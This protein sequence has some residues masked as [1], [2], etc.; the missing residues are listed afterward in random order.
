MLSRLL[1]RARTATRAG[2]ATTGAAAAQPL[3]LALNEAFARVQ[4]GDADGAQRAAEQAL[5]LRPDHAD[6]LYLRGLAEALRGA[7]ETA[8]EWFGR[9]RRA[10]PANAAF[11]FSAGLSARTLGR[12]EEAIAAWREAAR[13]DPQDPGTLD[14]L[15]VALLDAGRADEALAALSAAAALAGQD[16]QVAFHLGNALRAAGDEEAAAA[17]FEHACALRPEDARLHN[18]L[19]VALHA[20][21]R[22]SEA[23]SAFDRALA[24][25]GRYADAHN[26]RGSALQGLERTE[27]AVAAFARAL[28][29]DPGHPFALAN[30]AQALQETGRWR[31]AM[32]GFAAAAAAGSAGARLRHALVLPVIPASTGEI[33]EARGRIGPALDAIEAGGVTIADPLAEV[34][35]ANFHLAYHGECNRDL[36]ARIARAH[37]AACPSLAWTAPHVDR[38]RRPGRLRIGFLSRFLRAHSIGK[39]SRGLITRFS[40]ED[41]EVSCIHVPPVSGDE[42]ALAI[43]A[44][45]DRNAVLPLRLQAAREAVAALELDALFY[46]DIGMDPF[47]YLLAFARLAPVQ[48]LSFGH[49]DT[50]GIPNMDWFVSSDL[51]EPP[52]GASHYSER[53]WQA[54]DAGTLAWYLRPPAPDPAITRETLGLPADRPLYFCPHTHFRLHPEFDALLRAILEADPRGELLLIESRQPHWTRL[55]LERLGRSLGPHAARVRVLP[56]QPHPR[57]LALMRATDALLDP[58]HFN[59]MNNSLDAFAA[60]VPVVTWPRAL[61]R[62]RHT[63]GMYRRMGWEA[64]VARDADHYVSLAVRLGTDAEFRAV[65][66]R[67]VA[68]RSHVLFEDDHVVR[69]FERFFREVCTP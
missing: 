44:S 2:T 57:Y 48:C 30:R 27:E 51:Y 37:L 5:A 11:P 60:G 4:D 18:N 69:E 54:R 3:A 24:L 35:T 50:T 36:Q 29:H 55:L 46:Q 64:C 25:D 42:V 28:E 62:G 6:A 66:R 39:T 23:L 14:A 40:R 15:G 22:F 58:I 68:S 9:A 1:G 31:E 45:A 43:R 47:T 38:A 56:L 17:A 63:A 7:H 49:P 53:L 16:A 10:D 59:G 34:G 61:Q 65:A 26:N 21:S 32:E 12:L 33:A 67:E 20:L 52:D 8:L 19:G 13:L 41:F